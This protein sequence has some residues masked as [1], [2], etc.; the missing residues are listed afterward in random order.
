MDK[1]VKK[2][3]VN[4][5]M[6]EVRDHILSKIEFMPDNWDGIELRQYIYDMFKG[7]CSGHL[8]MTL[9]CKKEYNN[10]IQTSGRL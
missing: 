8:K 3:F 9:R 6:N 5:F 7:E 10:V 2:L 4:T 1:E